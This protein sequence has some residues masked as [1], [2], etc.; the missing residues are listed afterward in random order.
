[1]TLCRA[2]RRWAPL[3]DVLIECQHQSVEHDFNSRANDPWK[4][5][6]SEQAKDNAGEF[7][8]LSHR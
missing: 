5:V 2:I 4:G 1:M 6:V 8:E 7:V 3:L